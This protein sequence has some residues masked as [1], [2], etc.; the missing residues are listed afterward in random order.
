MQ[1][2]IMGKGQ[3]GSA[4]RHALTRAGHQVTFGSRKPEGSD[5]RSF[6]EAAAMADVIILAV[7]FAAVADVVEAAGSL[8]GKVVIDATNPLGMR[9][10]GLGLTSGF[11]TSGAEQIA[12]QAPDARVFKA[13]NQTGFE[14]LVDA[15][16]YANRPV[17]FVAGDDAAG[18]PLVMTLVADA[19]F[20]PVDLGGLTQARLLEPLAMLWIELA[21]KRGLGPDFSFTLQR[22][23]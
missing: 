11:S 18:K 6:A 16:A 1:I 14:N 7:P 9:D 21:R 5:D 4:L 2:A 13:F 22:K 23:A 20:E 15:P 3:V 17:M 10:D 8:R 12:A 19:G